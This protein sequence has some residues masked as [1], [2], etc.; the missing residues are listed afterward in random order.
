MD[1]QQMRGRFITFEGGEGA[2]KSTQC[3]LLRD[4]LLALGIDVIL[5]RE[6]GGTPTAEHIR[7]LLVSQGDPLHSKTEALLMF[8]A[9]C[10][11]WHEVIEPALKQGKWVISDRFVDSSYAYQGYG[12]GLDLNALK[13]LYDFAVGE[14]LPDL[15]I[16]L[17]LPPQIAFERITSRHKGYTERFEQEK[18]DFHERV[19]QGFLSLSKA[20]PQRYFLEDANQDIHDIAHEIMCEIERRFSIL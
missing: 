9:R 19:Y 4:S 2:G 6:P 13:N 11:H 3:V 8:A 12:R 20:Y 15:T 7:N 17:T 1:K 16:F 5:T 18:L 14:S 10:E